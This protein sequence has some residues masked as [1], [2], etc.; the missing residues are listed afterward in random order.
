MHG[1]IRSLKIVSTVHVT[2]KARFWSETFSRQTSVDY[3]RSAGV[4]KNG[5][6]TQTRS[7]LKWVLLKTVKLT[8]D[9]LITRTSHCFS[10]FYHF[11][12]RLFYRS[13]TTGWGRGRCNLPSSPIA[14]PYIVIFM[15]N[16]HSLLLYILL[17]C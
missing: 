17:S 10:M 11:S 2:I 13:V 1:D 3:C 14:F 9:F 6:H 16:V 5:L 4:S 8:M 12:S 15:Y 7:L